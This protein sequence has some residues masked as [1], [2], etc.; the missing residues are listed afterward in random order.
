MMAMVHVFDDHLV[1]IA[2]VA[3]PIG[4][5]VVRRIIDLRDRD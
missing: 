5:R 2:A 4:V 1:V 3:A